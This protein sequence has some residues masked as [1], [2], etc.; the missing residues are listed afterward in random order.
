MILRLAGMFKCFTHKTAGQCQTKTGIR[1]FDAAA[2]WGDCASALAQT[3]S[4]WAGVII[5]A[6]LAALS[7]VPPRTPTRKAGR[8]SAGA[9]IITR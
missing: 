8:A 1:P 4:L 5:C 6:V 3:P 9:Q 7:A 2:P